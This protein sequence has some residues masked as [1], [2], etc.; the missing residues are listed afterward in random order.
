M[1]STTNIKEMWEKY[2]TFKDEEKLQN[3]ENLSVLWMENACNS[4]FTAFLYIVYSNRK[5]QKSVNMP[6]NRN[7]CNF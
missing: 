6:R 4:K 1:F 2:S 7:C 5:R 3:V